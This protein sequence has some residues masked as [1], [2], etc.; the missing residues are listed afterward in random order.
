MLNDLFF[1]AI[2]N[3]LLK[4]KQIKVKEMNKQ[5][6]KARANQEI[7]ELSAKLNEFK[8]KKEQV[9]ESAQEK[10]ESL[11]EK[12]TERKSIAENQLNSLKEASEEKWG[13]A[14]KSFNAAQEDFKSGIK[15]LS[16]IF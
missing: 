7:D 9:K 8:A 3:I 11:I 2:I 14:K 1:I 10:Y 15:E 5:E 13:E 4:Y 12:L 6:L 16:E